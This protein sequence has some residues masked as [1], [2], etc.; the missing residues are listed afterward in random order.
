MIKKE[1]KNDILY[2]MWFCDK[3]DKMIEL[4]TLK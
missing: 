4:I 2:T 3:I 1:Q